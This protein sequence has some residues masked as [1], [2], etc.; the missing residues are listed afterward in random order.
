MWLFLSACVS[1]PPAGIDPPT[2]SVVIDTA[3]DSPADSG[4]SGDSEDSADTGETAETAETGETGD[5]GLGLGDF[6]DPDADGCPEGSACCAACCIPDL[7]P[8]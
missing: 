8:V 1:P 6:C 4:D 2:S 7:P 3:V 5:S